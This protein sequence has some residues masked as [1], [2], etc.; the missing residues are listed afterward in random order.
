MIVA[1]SASLTIDAPKIAGLDA[2]YL[3]NSLNNYKS[4]IRGSDPDDTYGQQMAP[5]AS[6]LPDDAAV[7]NISAYL[8]GL[9]PAKPA[10]TIE[11]NLER[12]AAHYVTCGACHGARGQGNVALQAPKLAGQED[13][14]L[15]RQLANFRAGIRGSHE[16]SGGSQISMKASWSR[17]RRARSASC[18]PSASASARPRPPRWA[19]PSAWC[20]PWTFAPC[21][22]A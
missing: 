1:I 7:R 15:K 18:R 8:A 13:W 10:T 3:R 14:Y 20:A 16:A 11:G 4:G 6:T 12:G 22:P 17:W 2:W 5:M 21:C 9:D 19:T